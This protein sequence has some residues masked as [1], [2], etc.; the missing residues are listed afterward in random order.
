MKTEIKIMY[1]LYHPNIIK[2]YNHFEEDDHIYLIIE[3]ASGVRKK[4]IRVAIWKI[5]R[6]VYF[7]NIL[8]VMS[9]IGR[10]LRLKEENKG[11]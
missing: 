11:V 2:L 8:V 5:F 10:R 3:F 1:G 7:E 6:L 4:I 9:R